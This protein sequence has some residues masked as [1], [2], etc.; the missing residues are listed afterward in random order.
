MSELERDIQP[1][2]IKKL[3]RRLPGVRI[4]KGDTRYKQGTPDLIIL[5]KD[6]WAMLEVK[7]DPHAPR[8][9][10]QQYYVDVLNTMSY[11][12]L[13]HPEN[14]EDILDGVQRA[15]QAERCPRISQP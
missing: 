8:R 4:F 1:R 2:I 6:R 11:A 14:E 3:E 10:N 13:I 9:P 7:K 15:L 5:Y 12:A